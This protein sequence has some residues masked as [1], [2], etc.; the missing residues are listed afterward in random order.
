MVKVQFNIVSEFLVE[1]GKSIGAIQ[2]GVVRVTREVRSK[3]NYPFQVVTVVATAIV[4]VPGVEGIAW[5]IELRQFVGEAL[6]GDN[7]RGD[8][9]HGNAD[10]VMNQIEEHFKDSGLD[11]RAGIFTLGGVAP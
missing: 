3:Q 10:K 6:V 4:T 11:I 2:G 9:V 5:L 1:L 7:V 8:P